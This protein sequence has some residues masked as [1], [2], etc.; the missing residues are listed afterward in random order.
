MM[1]AF[2]YEEIFLGFGWSGFEWGDFVGGWGCASEG[3]MSRVGTDL[4]M[5]E[6]S[7]LG[8]GD[9]VIG[10]GFVNSP[11]YVV[12]EGVAKGMVREFVME[13]GESAAYPGLKGPYRRRVIVYT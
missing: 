1:E 3:M 8:D 2:S 7:R 5:R 12:K 10:P 11:D 4:N 9:F 13:S 6:V